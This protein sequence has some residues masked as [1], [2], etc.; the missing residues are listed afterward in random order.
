MRETGKN[1]DLI[2]IIETEM[3]TKS[4]DEWINL[5]ADND[6]ACEKVYLWNEILTD[7]QCWANDV[8]QVVKYPAGDNI[9]MVNSPVKLQ[10]VGVP[11][12]RT[13]KEIGHDTDIVLGEL[14]YTGAEI[15]KMK[16]NCSS[17]GV[18]RMN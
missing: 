10:S 16:N 14:G 3:L 15:N 2:A 8:F 11:D 7:E 12:F 1:K 6:L 4:V 5:F 13:A 17:S 18:P 9:I